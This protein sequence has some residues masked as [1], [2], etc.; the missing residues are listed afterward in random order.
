MSALI[1]VGLALL[2]A[3]R[4]IAML[5]IIHRTTRGLWPKHFQRCFVPA[6]KSRNPNGRLAVHSHQRQ[7]KT[8]REGH[9]LDVA[10]HS[11]LGAVD[12]YN[13]LADY[14]VAAESVK[15]FQNRLQQI[16]K[17]GAGHKI[18][19]WAT[20]LSSRHHMFMHPLL[21]FSGF[22]GHECNMQDGMQVNDN[23][24]TTPTA[25]C[26]NGWLNMRD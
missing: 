4:D 17:I 2:N 5:G 19:G 16:L 8:Y 13:I 10:A 22:N 11:L 9:F 26:I 18:H 21:N 20:M 6:D 24:V 15:V 3:R 14:V 23:H 12:V 7:L 25:A 1:F